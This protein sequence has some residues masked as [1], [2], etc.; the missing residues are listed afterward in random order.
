MNETGAWLICM[1]LSGV[2]V[3]L[4][5]GLWEWEINDDQDIYG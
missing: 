5:R 3:L 2:I 1:M 4:L